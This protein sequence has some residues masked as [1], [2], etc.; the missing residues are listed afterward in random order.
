M[1]HAQRMANIPELA[2]SVGLQPYWLGTTEVGYG[3]ICI[4]VTILYKRTPGNQPTIRLR[5]VGVAML[6]H[7]LTT[8][9]SA[10]GRVLI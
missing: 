4:N 9:R 1:G 5:G 10:L 2:I 3:Y 8:G 7:D 6:I